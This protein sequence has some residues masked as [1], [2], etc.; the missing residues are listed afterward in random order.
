[1]V[2]VT[3]IIVVVA[4]V[5]MVAKVVAVDDNGWIKSELAI[6]SCLLP[7]KHLVG[8]RCILSTEK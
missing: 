7:H 5:V 2:V 3:T 8:G 6:L 4:M 1:M